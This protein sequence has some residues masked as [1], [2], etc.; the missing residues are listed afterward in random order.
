MH[1]K[2]MYQPSYSLPELQLEPS[3]SILAESDAMVSMTPN[4][5]MNT[6]AKG[7]LFGAFV[8]YLVSRLPFKH[9]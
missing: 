4:V 6:G 2:I 3:E 9:D 5:T 7:G 1:Y 8:N